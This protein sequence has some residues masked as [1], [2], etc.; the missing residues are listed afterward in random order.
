MYIYY[1][2]YT[3]VEGSCEKNRDEALE[4]WEEQQHLRPPSPTSRSTKSQPKGKAKNAFLIRPSVEDN[5]DFSSELLDLE[6]FPTP[7]IGI[8]MGG[9]LNSHRGHTRKW[10]LNK[11]TQTPGDS[12]SV[13]CCRKDSEDLWS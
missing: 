11:E 2:I 8:D 7:G 10:Y 3:H 13:R 1:H 6:V 12:W 5:P 9:V 4:A